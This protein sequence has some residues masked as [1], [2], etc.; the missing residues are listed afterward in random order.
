MEVYCPVAKKV[1]IIT[2]SPSNLYTCSGESSSCRQKLVLNTEAYCHQEMA[3]ID[4]RWFPES[5]I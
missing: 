5:K 3:G 1:V 2:G 4:P